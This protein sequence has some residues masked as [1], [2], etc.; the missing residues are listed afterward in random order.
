MKTCVILLVLVVWANAK[1]F[2]V[3]RQHPV[4]FPSR[5]LPAVKKASL[6]RAL[7][8][9]FK[10][11]KAKI[12]GGSSAALGQIPFHVSIESDETDFCNGAIIHPY[13][14][15]TTAYCVEGGSEFTIYAGVVKR[16]GDE[17]SRVIVK[18]NETYIHVGRNQHNNDGNIAL[19]KLP[20]G[21]R[22]NEYISA[23]LLPWNDDQ[24]VDDDAWISG[25]GSQDEGGALAPIL[26]YA[27]VTVISNEDCGKAYGSDMQT[28]DICTRAV[29][30]LGEC[31][32][33]NGG[34]LF[35]NIT[36]GASL[37]IGLSAF[38]AGCLTMAPDGF[39]RVSAY[40]DWINE[41][42]QST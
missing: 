26:Q 8:N 29:K 25:W 21:L 41:H 10:S 6:P 4:V 22:F 34:P 14:I 7:E 17:S 37:L 20:E 31:D 19:I 11:A 13:Y 18:S 16:H 32:Y 1:E 40:R 15:V 23:A 27:A 24:F 9:G 39:S 30:G 2:D 35:K 28:S 12:T 42:L 33:D 3:R 38:N 5:A 36:E